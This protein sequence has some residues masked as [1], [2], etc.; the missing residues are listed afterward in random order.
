MSISKIPV[1]TSGRQN[2][3]LV[4]I[5]FALLPFTACRHQPTEP[6][7]PESAVLPEASSEA[8]D[9]YFVMPTDTLSEYG[10]GSITRNM[11][12]DRNGNIWFSTWEGIVGYDGHVFTNYTLKYNLR[13]FHMFSLLEDSKGNLWFGSIRGGLYRYDPRASPDS[14]PFRLFTTSDGL[15]SDYIECLCEDNQ[16]NLWI[17]TDSGVSRINLNKL[18]DTGPPSCTNYTVADGLA[19]DYIHSIALDAT[20]KIW[21][22]TDGGVSWYNEAA[23]DQ[24]RS[25]EDI[26]K[27]DGNAFHNV[28]CIISTR[29]G[30]VILGGQDGLFRYEARN[31][32][33]KPVLTQQREDFIGYVY[34]DHEG[35]LWISHGNPGASGMSL[36][37]FDGD[38][39]VEMARGPQI[40]GILEDSRKS[41]WFETV[42]GPGRINENGLKYFSKQN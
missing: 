11:L 17:G 4:C 2:H 27:I 37:R 13:K 8:E 15:V 21:I 25:F 9:P 41:V 22:G 20:G 12:E 7:K 19:Y 35:Y 1:A 23:G 39:F 33:D 10:P 30:A 42:S 40:F 34:E 24:A 38:Q 16:G 31:A 36:S 6:S 26:N 29:F 3:L 28:R 14:N 32:L 5:L 18:S